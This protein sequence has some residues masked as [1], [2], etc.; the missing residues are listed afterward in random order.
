MSD[1]TTVST[2]V[3]DDAIVARVCQNFLDLGDLEFLN[4]FYEKYRDSLSQRPELFEKA[5]LIHAKRGTLPMLEWLRSKNLPGENA[6]LVVAVKHG[7]TDLLKA[8][9][10]NLPEAS[11]NALLS[12]AITRG[13]V[14]LV[15]AL[16][17]EITPTVQNAAK[18]A[19]LNGRIST[20]KYLL[21][22]G[23]TVGKEELLIAAYTGQHEVFKLFLQR[24]IPVTKEI[25]EAAI[26]GGQVSILELIDLSKFSFEDRLGFERLALSHSNLQAA[27]Y[28]RHV[29]H[30]TNTMTLWDLFTNM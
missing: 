1:V 25:V 18:Q 24:N 13:Q 27:Q 2:N 16:V 14:S 7:R 26:Q 28:L 23:L 10:P 4:P 9:V 19:I 21:E 6:A 17:S 5:W 15:E 8:L 3:I 29:M 30:R 20:V 12:E 22:K 11:Q